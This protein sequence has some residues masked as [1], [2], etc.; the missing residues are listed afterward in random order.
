MSIRKNDTVEV[1]SGDD[2]GKRGRVLHVMPENGRILVEGVNYIW[3]HVRPSQQ[4][5]Q[6]GRVQKESP[7]AI[8]NV[9]LL[10]PECGKGRAA[11]YSGQGRDKV[12]VC[13]KCGHEIPAG[14]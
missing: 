6:G 11:K 13:A 5:P 1:I 12:R 7:V 4:N 10:C 2:R 8:S 14:K 9:R 3:R